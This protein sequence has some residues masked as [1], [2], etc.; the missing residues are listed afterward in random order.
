MKQPALPH[1]STDSIA[2]HQVFTATLL[3]P[4][5]R[6][7][8]FPFCFI[9]HSFFHQSVWLSFKFEHHVSFERFFPSSLI[10]AELEFATPLR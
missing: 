9:P 7:T 2:P 6:W 5:H 10:N 4:L 3:S 8:L 1:G